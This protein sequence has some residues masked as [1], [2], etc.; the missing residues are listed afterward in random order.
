MWLF[1]RTTGLSFIGKE[2]I[3]YKDLKVTSACNIAE[4]NEVRFTTKTGVTLVYNYFFKQW[5]VFTNYEAEGA[6]FTLGTYYHLKTNGR[7]NAEIAN[8]Y[9]DNGASISLA[10]ETGWLSF[11]NVMGAQRI[12]FFYLLGRLYSP[13]YL[14]IK[15][16]YDYQDAWRET[17]VVNSSE[18]QP[19]YMNGDLSREFKNAQALKYA[20][21]T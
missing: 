16:A 9:N 13:H 1:D 7:V 21:K 19:L 2:V 4:Q 20:L 3:A 10:V 5:S 12:Y 6:V 15:F 17:I 8:Q 11:A 18:V 14:R